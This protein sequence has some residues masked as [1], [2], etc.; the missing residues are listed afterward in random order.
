MLK[1]FEESM[2][3]IKPSHG[4]VQWIWQNQNANFLGLYTKKWWKEI[5]DNKLAQTI[6][7]RR[8]PTPKFY[9]YENRSFSVKKRKQSRLQSTVTRKKFGKYEIL[10]REIRKS[11]RNIW[12]GNFIFVM[13]GA[14]GI[15][16]V[17]L[18][19]FTRKLFYY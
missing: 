1:L 18:E 4:S 3:V 12:N 10:Y 7:N 15:F 14:G 16:L 11:Q 19:R 9:Y 5:E 17:K 2:S 6:L 13:L 8:P